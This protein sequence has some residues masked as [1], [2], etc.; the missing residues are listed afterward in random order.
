MTK[1]LR[2][3]IKLMKLECCL[4]T[5]IQIKTLLINTLNTTLIVFIVW[6]GLT[7]CADDIMSIPVTICLQRTKMYDFVCDKCNKK[8]FLACLLS[9]F[10][11]GSDLSRIEEYLVLTGFRKLETPKQWLFTWKAPDH[12]YVLRVV[13]TSDAG[14]KIVSISVP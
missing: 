4:L 1:K 6:I 12:K 3:L 2:Q 10:P 7:K 5:Q 8:D 9:R 14:G 11:L 13:I